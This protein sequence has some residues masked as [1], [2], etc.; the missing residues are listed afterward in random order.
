MSFALEWSVF[1]TQTHS[2]IY[3]SSMAAFPLTGNTDPM[4]HKI[5]KIYPMTP[6]RENVSTSDSK[7]NLTAMVF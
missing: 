5:N 3:V 6:Y 7:I 4:T 2:F 1:G